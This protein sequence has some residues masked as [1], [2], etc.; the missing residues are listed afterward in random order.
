LQTLRATLMT[1]LAIA[2]TRRAVRHIHLLTFDNSGLITEH[3]AV[4]D[5]IALMRQLGA[6]PQAMAR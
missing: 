5:D 6:E 2:A 4:R 1:P 3:F